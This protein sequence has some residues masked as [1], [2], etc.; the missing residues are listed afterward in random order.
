MRIALTID[1]TRHTLELEATTSLYEAIMPHAVRNGRCA[2]GRCLRCVVMLNDRVVPSCAVPVYRAHEATIRT[3]PGLQRDA[4]TG[5]IMSTIRR[6]FERVGLDACRESYASITV[7][8][9]SILHRDLNPTDADIQRVSRHLS[10]RCSNRDDFERAIR[11]AAGVLRRK[12]HE[13]SS[14][15]RPA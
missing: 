6:A 7:L 5:E 3:A 10:D 12:A 1:E 11:L 14:G 8:A 9:Y 15:T 2:D 4:D 13:Q